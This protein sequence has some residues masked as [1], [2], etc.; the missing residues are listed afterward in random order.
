MRRDRHQKYRRLN[1]SNMVPYFA[2]N[3]ALGASLGEHVGGEERQYAPHDAH[4]DSPPRP[5]AAAPDVALVGMVST[6]FRV[7]S[8]YPAR[9]RT[10]DFRCQLTYTVSARG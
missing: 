3:D 1:D 6:H 7:V 10:V 2:T 8:E 4:E 9:A 5:A